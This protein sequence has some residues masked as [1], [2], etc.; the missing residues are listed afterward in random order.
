MSYA[1]DAGLCERLPANG[2]TGHIEY[3][4]LSWQEIQAWQTLTR[5]PLLPSE[6]RLIRMFSNA[7]ASEL[8]LQ[9]NEKNPLRFTPPE[10]RPEF[11][12]R[13]EDIS[14]ASDEEVM[15]MFS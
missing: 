5:T 13:F 2:M 15:K 12:E 6:A 8:S 7:Y 10:S 11:I 14:F 3:R 1:I 9:Q 4:P